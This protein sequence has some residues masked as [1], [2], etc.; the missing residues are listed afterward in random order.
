MTI[1]RIGIVIAPC[2]VQLTS[3]DQ[4]APAQM[5]T[6]WLSNAIGELIWLKSMAKDAKE[7][8][9]LNQTQICI[10]EHIK[11]THFKIDI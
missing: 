1:N 5:N 4:W 6:S 8:R 10:Y 7:G 9:L 2:F 11:P 3:P